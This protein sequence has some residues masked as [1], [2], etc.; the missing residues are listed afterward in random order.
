M[1][2]S[3]ADHFTKLCRKMFPDSKIAEHYACARTKTTAFVTHAMA[4]AADDAVSKACG[5]QPFSIMCDGGN[6]QFEKKYFGIMV[7]YWD[8]TCGKVV[9]RFLDMPVCNIATS[10]LLFNALEEVLM[11]RAIPWDNVIGFASDSAS[12]MIG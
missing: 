11:K 5:S 8:E 4:P 3:S 7:R 1:P 12:V 2:F 6:D 10:Q 9:T